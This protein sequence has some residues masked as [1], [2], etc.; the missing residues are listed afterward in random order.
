M[1]TWKKVIVSGSAADLAEVSAS[2][3]FIGDGS[4][5]T[6][7]VDASIASNAAIA[8]TKLAALA[9]TKVLVGNGSN[10]ATE[11]ALS[12]D[13]TM[14]NAGAVTIANTA[15]TNA[16]I[17]D[18]AVDTEEIADD[19][20]DADKLA[21]NAVVN[22]SIA[23]NAAIAHSK[24]A[25]LA[26]TKV[27]VGNGSNVAAEV[28]LS[29]DV[30]MD[31]TGA[32]TVGANKITLAK[33]AGLARGKLISGD[34][35]GDP[36]ALAAGG[37]NTVLQS[38][39]TDITY[40]TVATAMIADNAVSLAKMAGLARGKIIAGDSSGDPA[41]LAVGSANTVLQ[42]DGTDVSYGTV[43]TA[44]IADDAVDADKLAANAV[45][46]ASIASNAAIAHS[47]LA[48][49]NNGNIFVGNAGNQATSTA[50]SGDVTINGAGAVTI[51]NNAVDG[52]KL[53]DSFTVAAELIIAGHGL[54]VKQIT[55]SGY[56]SASGTIEADAF[57]GDGSELTGVTVADN[58]ITLAKMAGLARGKLIVG[59]SSGDPAALAAGGANTVLQSDG[60]DITYNTVATAMIADNAVSLAKMS[61]LAR[62]K[63][64]SGDSSGDP[65][66]LAAGGAN[67]V[68]QSDGT[69][70]TY[71]T[72]ATA[73]IADNAVSLAKMAGLA[74]GKII[75]GDS[76][77]DPVAL[78]A[79]GAN[80]VL[81]SDGTDITY[82]TVATAMIADDAVDADKLASNAVVNASIAANAAIAHS[83]LAALASTKVLVGNGSN[84]AAEVAL[85]G[86]V[87][88]NN[89]GAVTIGANKV[90]LAKMAGLARGKI[91]S[92]DSS[93]DPVALAAGGANTVL[94]SDGTDITYNTVATAMI[95]DNAVS[96]AKMASIARGKIIL[97]NSSGNPALLSP[98]GANTVLQSDGTDITYNTVATAMIADDAVDADKL[99][100]N[101]VVNASV[102]ANAAIA[103]SKLAA[104]AATKVLVGNGS[105]VATEVALSG[106]VTMNNAGA[107]TIAANAVDGDK[108]ADSIVIAADLTVT[109]DL[110]VSGDSVTVNTA[111]LNVEDPFILLK[112]GS[113]NTSDSGVIFGGSTGTANSGKA[114]VW[115]ASYNSNDGRLAVSTTAVAGDAT[116]NFDGSGTAGYYI[117]GVFAGSEADAATAKADH[118]GNIRIES[119]EIFIY[120]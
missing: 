5:L 23:A 97:G 57:L 45:V 86:D 120:V 39:G 87:T 102:A 69:D 90:T 106:D 6:G 104:L 53:A 64:I 92:G 94:Q 20:I 54:T 66:A 109:G 80:T 85:S 60:T 51:A 37:A 101:A 2:V 36:V 71:N 35:S 95:A 38:D 61:G 29:G 34:S 8:H 116:A 43:A 26:S 105:N 55:A 7:I 49:L 10:V 78:A 68:L 81:Q 76:S 27:L 30:T 67:T 100:S 72:V 40:N 50:V 114:I 19:A 79:G 115:D 52:D 84:V 25:A 74:R 65:V 108:L 13:V 42:S 28:A 56:I 21:S 17:G 113:S 111:N 31:N 33:M 82:N 83:K 107:V 12:G 118:A 58:A 96:L 11:V 91:I 77:G 75:S 16:M 4:A 46:N 103:H 14:D 47:K 32:V 117:A 110:L 18:G 41:A 98:G 1:A 44:M 59:D 119:S 93:G 88:M 22:A 3:G 62:G 112:S 73:M 70:I 24:L 99:A 9:A 63:I 89:A 48:A 15:V